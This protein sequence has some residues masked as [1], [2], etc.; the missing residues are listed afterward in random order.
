MTK[1]H[2]DAAGK[3]LQ[4]LDTKSKKKERISNS[5]KTALLTQVRFSL[6]DS[7]LRLSALQLF[8]KVI[9]LRE[10]E[11]N[12][13]VSE[14]AALVYQCVDEIGTILLHHGGDQ[15]LVGVCCSIYVEFL[16]S[17]PMTEKIQQKRVAFLIR[18]LTFQSFEGR[19]AMLA[20]IHE[21]AVSHP[22]S[23]KFSIKQLGL[24]E[25]VPN[26]R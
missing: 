7:R 11:A 9:L 6:D 21:L 17:Y 5:F 25:T 22:L 3:R 20:V 23:K 1:S 15:K 10:R 4:V 19:R 13:Q 24:K 26:D 16:M 14:H 12:L 8:Q 18:N 2:Y